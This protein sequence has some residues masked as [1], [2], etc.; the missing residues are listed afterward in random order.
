MIFTGFLS[1]SGKSFTVPEGKGTLL[2]ACAETGKI[3]GRCKK[4]F[5]RENPADTS[6]IKEKKEENVGV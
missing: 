2:S 3:F 1:S 6:F 5:E 4:Q